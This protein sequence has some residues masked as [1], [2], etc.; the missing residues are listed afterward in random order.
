MQEF[1]TCLGLILFF[2]SL[3]EDM[4][5]DFRERGKKR[6]GRER[7][8]YRDTNCSLP[9]IPNR[10]LNL[11]AWGTWWCSN[12]LSHLARSW[13]PFLVTVIADITTLLSGRAEATHLFKGWD[14]FHTHV[15]SVIEDKP[16]TSIEK[17]PYQC[18]LALP[19][20]LSFSGWFWHC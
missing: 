13:V 19:M 11:Q 14:M 15:D 6:G 16:E 17:W 20:I 7:E 2:K 18:P 5:I 4:F 12:Q 10:G 8:G 9:M 3:Y 1:D